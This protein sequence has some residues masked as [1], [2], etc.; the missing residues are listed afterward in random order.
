MGC[1][2]IERQ[3]HTICMTT[4]VFTHAQTP[5]IIL[6]DSQNESGGAMPME[7]IC[8]E[9]SQ[10]APQACHI[11]ALRIFERPSAQAMRNIKGARDEQSIEM[12]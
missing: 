7:G 11:A 2:G 1:G 10:N 8:Q 4:R 5:G 3:K 12:T 9:T 6:P